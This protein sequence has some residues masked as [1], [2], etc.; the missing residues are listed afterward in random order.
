[1][2]RVM[3]KNLTVVLEPENEGEDGGVMTRKLSGS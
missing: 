1:M 2:S 3:P